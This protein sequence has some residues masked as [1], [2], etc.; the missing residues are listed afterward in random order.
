MKEKLEKDI[1][2][3]ICDYLYEKNYFFWRQNNVPV[4]AKSNDGVMRFRALPKYTLK[5]IPD[6]LLLHK[7]M[8]CGFEVKRPCAVLRPEQEIFGNMIKLNGGLYFVV[9]SLLEVQSIL[10]ENL[11]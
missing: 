6:I 2:R 5:G 9:T 3:E 8:F 11:K 4:F 7:G 1:Q 10:G